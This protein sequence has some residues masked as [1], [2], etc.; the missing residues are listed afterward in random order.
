M[1]HRNRRETLPLYKMLKFQDRET[2][3]ARRPWVALGSAR[4]QRYSRRNLFSIPFP[5]RLFFL[6]TSVSL[7]FPKH[8]ESW[9]K[10]PRGRSLRSSCSLQSDATSTVATERYSLTFSLWAAPQQSPVK[11]ARGSGLR[12]ITA[13]S[14]QNSPV[15]NS[16]EEWHTV[17]DDFCDERRISGRCVQFIILN[18]TLWKL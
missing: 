11:R 7:H 10:S 13:G 6:A 14:S 12:E 5:D 8:P 1:P 2:V 16:R 9:C 17:E 3:S 4:A 15:T 18:V